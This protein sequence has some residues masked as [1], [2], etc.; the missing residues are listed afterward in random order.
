MPATTY[1]RD[2]ARCA[3]R[4]YAND[5]HSP[6]RW[7]GDGAL[8]LGLDGP[9][10]ARGREQFIGLLDGQDLDGNR[11]SRPVVR[12]DPAGSL[13]A[14]PLLEA[15]RTVAADRRQ[16][17]AELFPDPA[18]RRVVARA[19]E[20][21]AA[22][23]DARTVAEIAQ[24][25]GLDPAS[26]YRTA[27]GK[28]GF[29]AALRHAGRV[30]DARR[31]GIDVTVSAPKSISALAGLAEPD[32]ARRIEACH[33]RAVGQA[34]GY[35][36]RHAGHAF[37]GHHGDGQQ[38]SQ[39]GT[40]GWI[41]A[42]FT[43]HTSRADDPQ[44][45]THLVVPNLLHGEDRRWSAIDSRA[46]HRH[47]KTAGYLYQAALRHEISKDLGLAWTDP[48]MGVAE[49]AGVPVDVLREFSTRRRQIE[50]ATRG[51][52]RKAAQVACLATR[53]DK[54]HRPVASLRDQWRTRAERGG[55]TPPRPTCTTEAGLPSLEALAQRLLGPEGVTARRTDFDVRDLVQALAEMLPPAASGD[56]QAIEDLAHQLLLHEDAVALEPESGAVR[57][58]SRQ[59][60]DT[61]RRALQLA[62]TPA[63]ARAVD[64]GVLAATLANHEELSGAQRR[65]V[66]TIAADQRL[67]AVLVGPAGSGKTATLATLADLWTRQGRP[68][69]GVALA[70]L[71]AQRLQADSGIPSRTV[72][73]LLAGTGDAI[74]LGAVVVVDEA[75]MVGTRQLHQLL[76][77]THR[78]GG[79]LLLVG[80]PAQLPEIDAGG[81]FR[82]LARPAAR[83][84][85]LTG[86]QRQSQAWE[87][88]SL[89]ALRLGDVEK[90][91]RSY[92]A[93]DRV[94]TNPDRDEL[95]GQL[96]DDYL[97]AGLGQDAVV[98]ATRRRDVTDLNGLIRSRL[99]DRGAL[100]PDVDSLPGGLDLAPG[101]ELIT[102]RPVR[103]AAR[104]KLLNGT[105]LRLAG[106]SSRQVT[107][108]D[109]TTRY[110]LDR[111]TAAASLQHGYA[112]TIHKAQG[113]TVDTA[114]VL[115]DG[116]SH[117]AAYTALSRG[118]ERNQ[119]YLHEPDPERP[120]L[121]VL[122]AQLRLPAGDELA[123]LR[124][125]RGV[126]HRSVPTG[127]E[128]TRS[129]QC[130][131]RDR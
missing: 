77:Q 11:I 8:S 69:V 51:S 109:G 66:L 42:A 34:L 20:T 101:D 88:Q 17:V 62:A 7:L 117:N 56:G 112:L 48:V 26:L 95:L 124:L 59:L 76:E 27:R 108:E 3:D 67:A 61:E 104:Q 25:S 86:N 78:A 63:A 22:R 123:V 114:L 12:A 14:A 96:A 4:Y 128:H 46:V 43:H 115:T 6:G 71:T 87:Q 28:D 41:V 2:D 92:A 60:V 72:A 90:A 91:L 129:P 52:G 118:R 127:P 13:P 116:L 110:V 131:G 99:Q 16:S 100:G 119:L 81:L 84:A 40:D 85:V 65:A 39:V 33:I 21:P 94:T 53:P 47:A 113:L 31:T 111:A 50:V 55:F 97:D 103:T 105:R 45:H 44:L 37:R 74:P 5:G 23:L 89:A 83:P 18:L 126:V 107:V 130:E 75:G 102:T 98:L 32:M 54:S 29:G 82:H 49:L 10:D 35:L 24:A 58:T 36:Q 122:A 80:D 1:L 106:V 38:L 68:V 64:R 9:L 15:L 70:A 93:H 57:W 120:A 19:Q 121:D 79:Q 73:S 30:I 125:P